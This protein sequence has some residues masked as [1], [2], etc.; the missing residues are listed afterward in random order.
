MCIGSAF[1]RA[2]AALVWRRLPCMRWVCGL[3]GV[4]PCRRRVP[5]AHPEFACFASVNVFFR[6]GYRRRHSG[7]QMLTLSAGAHPLGSP[8]CSLY[9]CLIETCWP[10]ACMGA[11]F[12]FRLVLLLV[13]LLIVGQQALILHS[14]FYWNCQAVLAFEVGAIS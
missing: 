10:R 4:S 2:A 14:N 9:A 5:S 8:V 12:T 1:G 11:V 3:K 6:E 13:V 7:M